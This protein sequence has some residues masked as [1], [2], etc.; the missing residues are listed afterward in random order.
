MKRMSTGFYIG[1]YV[2]AMLIGIGLI[3]MAS[4]LFKEREEALP[5]VC[6]G[7][8]I[9][10]F[11][12]VVQSVFLYKIWAAIQGVH[13]RTTPGRAVGFMFIP[14]YN[15]YWVF[16]AVG[17]WAPDYNKLVGDSGARLMHASEGLGLAMSV[18]YL[19]CYVSGFV[20]YG[21][22]I[23][24]LANVVLWAVFIQQGCSMVNDLIEWEERQ[25]TQAGG[26]L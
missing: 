17:G 23:V 11:G 24:G 1:S 14:F 15:L 12:V 21:S 13:A 26:S 19:V 22:T 25:G 3:T 5:F 9:M 20:P 10:L 16:Q 2:A 4:T 7:V 8:P 18:V 6:A